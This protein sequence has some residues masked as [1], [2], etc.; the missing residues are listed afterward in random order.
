MANRLAHL[1]ASAFD[2]ILDQYIQTNDAWYRGHGTI[3]Q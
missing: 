3:G 1:K 2:P